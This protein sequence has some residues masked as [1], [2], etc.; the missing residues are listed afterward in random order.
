MTFCEVM[1]TTTVSGTRTMMIVRNWRFRY[2][3]A[4]SWIAVAISIIFGVPWSSARTCFIRMNPTTMAR[5]AAKPERMR[6]AH[7]PPF[8]TNS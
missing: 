6:I 5:R 4:P 8:S 7:S 3:A 1:N 2:A